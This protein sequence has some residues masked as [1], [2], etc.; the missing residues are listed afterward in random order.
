MMA[1]RWPVYRA[2]VSFPGEVFSCGGIPEITGVLWPPGHRLRSP[3]GNSR[4]S[5]A[6]L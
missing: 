5:A 3:A 1:H 6:C 4:G 2:R